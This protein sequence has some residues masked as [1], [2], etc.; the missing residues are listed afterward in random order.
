MSTRRAAA[1]ADGLPEMQRRLGPTARLQSLHRRCCFCYHPHRHQ[2]EMTARLP[3]SHHH[4]HRRRQQLGQEGPVEERQ[5]ET[6]DRGIPA[7]CNRVR[8]QYSSRKETTSCQFSPFQQVIRLDKRLDFLHHL[9]AI[10]C[11]LRFCLA[12]CRLPHHLV[13]I[14]FDARQLSNAGGCLHTTRK[15]PDDTE[16]NN[17]DTRRTSSPRC[18]CPARRS[19]TGLA[20]EEEASQ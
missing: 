18:P 14:L 5:Q 7:A 15:G 20:P 12:F 3:S 9:R 19:T 1:A 2:L 8:Q 16:K 17:Q 11:A 6:R 13:D 10:Q 4:H